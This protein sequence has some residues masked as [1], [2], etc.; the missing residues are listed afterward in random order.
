MCT[1]LAFTIRALTRFEV[2]ELKL[3]PFIPD[4]RYL[5]E[6][7]YNVLFTTEIDHIYAK[8]YHKTA[9]YTR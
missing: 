2:N 9:H 3:N 7:Q 4:S 5:C 1:I 8:I 6:R